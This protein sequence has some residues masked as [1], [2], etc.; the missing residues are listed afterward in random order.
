MVSDLKALI[1][2][3]GLIPAVLA[4]FKQTPEFFAPSPAREPAIQWAAALASIFTFVYML[5]HL[6]AT[7]GPLS[8]WDDAT[9][10]RRGLQALVALGLVVLTAIAYYLLVGYFPYSSR[11]VN[12]LQIAL[13]SAPFALLT[14]ALTVLACIWI[15]APRKAE[16]KPP[17]E[18]KHSPLEDQAAGE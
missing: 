18:S 13:W 17:A 7:R 9:R 8:S 3:I 10:K 14:Y 6:R 2:V 16:S 4:W 5:V 12:V 15:S 1:Q 11:I